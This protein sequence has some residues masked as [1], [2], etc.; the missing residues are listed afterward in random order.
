MSNRKYQIKTRI[1]NNSR[2]SGNYYKLVFAAPGIA[3]IV[4]PGQFVMVR[5]SQGYQPLL[6]RP[7]SIHSVTAK[8]PV[9]PAGRIEIL[10]EIV[11]KGTQILSGK[12]PGAYLDILG[13][14]GNGFSRLDTRH[15]ILVGGGMGV[16]PLLFLAQRLSVAGPQQSTVLIGAR[17]KKEILCQKKFA[18]LGYSVRISTDDGSGGFRG[19]ATE[20]LE[21]LLLTAICQPSIIYA[22]GPKPMLQGISGIARRYR[23]PAQISLEEYM[24]CGLGV[25]LGCMVNTKHGFQAVCK[26]GPVFDSGIIKW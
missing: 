4:R 8:K 12:K 7:F 26:D 23:I 11:G 18:N 16:A 9:L 21:H 13:P 20:L 25:C 15:S 1:I 14:L 24:A 5:I 2:I 19:R 6:R 17:T 3:R 10:Y 22:C